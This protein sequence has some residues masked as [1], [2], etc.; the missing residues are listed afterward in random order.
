MIR[1]L[2]FQSLL[3]I[4]SIPELEDAD[5]CDFTTLNADYPRV[6]CWLSYITLLLSFGFTESSVAGQVMIS[7]FGDSE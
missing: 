1:P 5:Q 4:L 3:P 7:M 2:G 6:T